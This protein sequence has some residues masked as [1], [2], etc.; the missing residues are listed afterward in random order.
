MLL[1]GRLPSHA[2]TGQGMVPTQHDGR[3]RM[4]SGGL[5]GLDQAIPYLVEG[6]INPGG[7][8]FCRRGKLTGIR[9]CGWRCRAAM[10]NYS[11]PPR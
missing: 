5:D 10:V 9:I 11:N 6:Q 1:G 4:L 7:G 3:H 8:W 2:A